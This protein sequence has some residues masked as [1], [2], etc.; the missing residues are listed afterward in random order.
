MGNLRY[1]IYALF[2]MHVRSVIIFYGEEKW[3]DEI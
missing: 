1:S 3:I 2:I